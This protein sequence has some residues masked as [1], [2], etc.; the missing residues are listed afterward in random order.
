MLLLLQEPQR[1][2][3]DPDIGEGVE[4]PEM[5]GVVLLLLLLLLH[6]VEGGVFP[7]NTRHSDIKTNISFYLNT[8]GP[9]SINTKRPFY[10]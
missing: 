7:P 5:S 10:L 2:R 1:F 8:N 3:R 6:L 4:C 9:L